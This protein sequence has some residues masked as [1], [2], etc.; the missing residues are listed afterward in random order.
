MPRILALDYGARRTGLAWTDPL[1]LIA[2]GLETVETERL[3]ARLAAIL[4]A[5]AVEAIVIGYPTRA[6]GS[7]SHVT[8]AVRQLRA[9]L[10]AAHPGLAFHFQDERFSS[11]AAMRAMVAGGLRRKQR[12]DRQL[13]NEVSAVL[14]LQAF[15]EENL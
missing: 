1:K 11:Q 6:D 3:E 14:L 2:T 15:M 4:A 7:D 5:E 13:I 10:Q 12:R 9:R 8:E